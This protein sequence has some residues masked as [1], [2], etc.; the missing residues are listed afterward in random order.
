MRA[1]PWNKSI[2]GKSTRSGQQAA[3]TQITDAGVAHHLSHT[4]LGPRPVFE[5]T[6][7]TRIVTKE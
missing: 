4:R 3:R 1:W 2:A 5:D 7:T 6:E